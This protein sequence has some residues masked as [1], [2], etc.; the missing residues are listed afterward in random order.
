M[1]VAVKFTVWSTVTG[2]VGTALNATVG[3]VGVMVK[4]TTVDEAELKFEFVDVNIASIVCVAAVA[5]GARH[6]GATPGVA[7]VS[8]SRVTVHSRV[9]GVVEVSI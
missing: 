2:E 6:G 1:R 4:F 3:A 8:G 7:L 9:A 5:I